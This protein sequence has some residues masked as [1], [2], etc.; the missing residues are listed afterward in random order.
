MAE[1]APKTGDVAITFTDKSPLSDPV[2][3]TR[4]GGWSLEAIKKQVDIDYDLSKET[5]AAYI[6]ASYDGTKPYGLMIWINAGPKGD[7]PAAWKPVLDQHHLIWI[8]A[9]NGGNPRAMLVRMGMA[10]DA[11]ENMKSRYQIDDERVYIAGTSGGG[12]VAT[13]LGV[14]WPEAFRG[15]FYMIGTC[16]YRDVPTGEPGHLW[17]RGFNVPE[18]KLLTDSK[19][20]NRHV[21]FTGEKDMN[22][23]PTLGMYAAYKGDRFQ[24]LTLLDAPG[25]GHE[26]PSAE[27]FEKGVVAL[28]EIPAK[29][30]KPVKTR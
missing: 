28:D 11:A 18:P 15:G 5:F 6:P 30:V 23:K 4:R 8:G 13:I 7:I 26:M 20:R 10:L 1:D 24:H 27:W 25:M 21:F 22:R 19:Q 14:G 12:K 29:V 16:H 9:N 3:L 17:P 2:K